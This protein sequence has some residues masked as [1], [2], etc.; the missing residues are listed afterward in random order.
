MRPAS[1]TPSP[2]HKINVIVFCYENHNIWQD[3]FCTKHYN[4]LYFSRFP[5]EG[6]SLQINETYSECFPVNNE[7]KLRNKM[8]IISAPCTST[9]KI[10]SKRKCYFL[11]SPV[12]FQNSHLGNCRKTTSSHLL[13][14]YSATLAC[15]R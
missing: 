1:L 13:Q 3:K 2:E 12:L 8:K 4:H 15:F 7:G 11:S 9:I 6:R 5:F 10:F 14:N